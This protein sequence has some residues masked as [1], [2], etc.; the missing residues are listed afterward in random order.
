MS[1]DNLTYVSLEVRSVNFQSIFN[2]TVLIMAPKFS[3]RHHKRLPEGTPSTQP[4]H[5]DTVPY[6]PEVKFK[7]FF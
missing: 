3:C 4:V 6:V 7:H 5:S 1:V 2:M